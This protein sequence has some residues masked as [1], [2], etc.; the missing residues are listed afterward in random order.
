MG[1]FIFNSSECRVAGMLAYF[2]EK[3]AEPCGKCDVCRT[4]RKA[5]TTNAATDASHLRKQVLRLAA[6]PRTTTIDYIAE[7]LSVKPELLIPIVRQL[8][9]DGLLRASGSVLT[10]RQ[11]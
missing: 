10:L 2:G 8:L 11:E 1:E 6:Q 7:Q 3:S 4:H 9:D 5:A